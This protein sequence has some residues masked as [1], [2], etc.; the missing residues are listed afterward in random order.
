MLNEFGA[1]CLT[2]PVF[3]TLVYFLILSRHSLIPH[4]IFSYPLRTR[5]FPY[6][7]PHYF[8][9][10]TR[11]SPLSHFM[12]PYQVPRYLIVYPLKSKSR[13]PISPCLSHLL[14]SP[15]FLSPT[16]SRDSDPGS[17]NRLFSP[18]PSYG[19]RLFIFIAR[20]LQPF[21]PS[22]TCVELRPPTLQ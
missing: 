19:S 1:I 21:L 4:S 7:L 18:P 6:L 13:F 22:S 15:F 16:P 5:A 12:L 17:P 20:G 14:S 8:P 9:Y 10:L 11:S 2:Q 3:A